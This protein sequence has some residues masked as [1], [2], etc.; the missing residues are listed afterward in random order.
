MTVEEAAEACECD[1]ATWYRIE[2]GQSVLPLSRL[3]AI[4][5]LLEV[6]D[7]DLL[8]RCAVADDHAKPDDD[9]EPV[10]TYALEEQMDDDWDDSIGRGIKKGLAARGD[11]QAQESD[12]GDN[13]NGVP[14]TDSDVD[15]A[16]K[17]PAKRRLDKDYP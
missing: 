15:E 1:Q 6:K 3:E 4:A 11:A 2:S 5:E 9:L 16:G 8:R 14:L 10:D 13:G 17:R 7:I 12:A